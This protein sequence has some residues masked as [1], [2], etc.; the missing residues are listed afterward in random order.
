MKPETPAP[1]CSTSWRVQ[2]LKEEPHLLSA[3]AQEAQQCLPQWLYILYTFI[4]LYTASLVSTAGTFLT[5]NLELLR[6]C[7]RPFLLH[8]IKQNCLLPQEVTGEESGGREIVGY[9]VD[10]VFFDATPILL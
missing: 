7:E 8:T 1:Q 9:S 3:H 4:V 2:Q 10:F 6:T 5:P